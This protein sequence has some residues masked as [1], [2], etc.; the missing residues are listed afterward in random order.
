[1]SKLKKWYHQWTIKEQIRWA[2]IGL[3]GLS[4]LLLAVIGFILSKSLI[5]KSYREDFTYNLQVSNEI[6]DIQL[7]NIIEIA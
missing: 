5:E 1:M 7:K 2:L 4:A 6:M 3:A